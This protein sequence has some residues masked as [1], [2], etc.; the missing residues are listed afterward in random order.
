MES[1]FCA[2]RETPDLIVSTLRSLADYPTTSS[3]DKLQTSS[4][5]R[6]DTPARQAIIKSAATAMSGSLK[7]L[8]IHQLREHDGGLRLSLRAVTA[9]LP[10]RE[11]LHQTSPS[12]SQEQSNLPGRTTAELRT[13]IHET[14]RV[15]RLTVKH[16]EDSTVF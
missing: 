3:A 4:K 14:G 9:M 5:A 10:S 1:V 8:E 7:M 11:P 13:R 12:V 2:S 15:V 16:D 6:L